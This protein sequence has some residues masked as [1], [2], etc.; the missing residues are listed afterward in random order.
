MEKYKIDKCKKSDAL[1]LY[2]LQV[3]TNY[4]IKIIEDMINNDRIIFLKAVL[5]NK[6]IGYC[7]LETVLDEGEIHSVLVVKEHRGKGIAKELVK[8]CI[9]KTSTKKVFLEVNE[10]NINAINLYKGLG[11][12]PISKRQK[13]YGTD[14]AIIMEMS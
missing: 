9:K 6:I 4:T 3:C 14:D 12:M 10:N 13:Y 7:S 2:N 5:N 11:F 8:A 1:E